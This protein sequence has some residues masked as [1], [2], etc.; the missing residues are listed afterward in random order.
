MFLASLNKVSAMSIV[1][2]DYC[3]FDHLSERRVA[4]LIALSPHVHPGSE[5]HV[6]EC[7]MSHR[8]NTSQRA[9]RREAAGLS[10]RFSSSGQV[11][12]PLPWA[13]SS[14]R[15]SSTL[16]TCESTQIRYYTVAMIMCVFA[17]VCIHA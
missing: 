4:Q 6:G 10:E 5:L 15:L 7:I 13:T 16:F 17:V 1:L 14:L 8:A 12:A 2:Y 9:S 3:E 11:Y